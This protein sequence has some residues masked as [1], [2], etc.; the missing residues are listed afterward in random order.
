MEASAAQAFFQAHKDLFQYEKYV[1][2]QDPF[3]TENTK[4]FLEKY[5]E[6]DHDRQPMPAFSELSFSLLHPPTR[7]FPSANLAINAA[8][9]VPEFVTLHAT[10]S[11][12]EKL[13]NLQHERIRTHTFASPLQHTTQ[14]TQ[15]QPALRVTYDS[16]AAPQYP[17]P[18]RTSVSKA[19]SDRSVLLQQRSPIRLSIESKQNIFALPKL[20][21]LLID[22]E[23]R[24]ATTAH[25]S[26]DES[27]KIQVLVGNNCVGRVNAAS[28]N[29]PPSIRSRLRASANVSVRRER[30]YDLLRRDYHELSKR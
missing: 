27:H 4:S 25:K 9:P 30:L 18:D 3:Q 13:N 5:R 7:R 29:L 6:I 15:P 2:N 28:R 21:E 17:S 20:A 19:T 10:A 8:T 1:G 16:S 26:W 24:A 14:Y 11:A 22:R 23:T 12:L